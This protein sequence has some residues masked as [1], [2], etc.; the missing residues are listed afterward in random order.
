[1]NIFHKD[2]KSPRE[3]D[4]FYRDLTNFSKVSIELKPTYSGKL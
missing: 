1:M 2:E 3:L 4:I